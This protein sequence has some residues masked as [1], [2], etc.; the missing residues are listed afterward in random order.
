MIFS[1]F[2]IH[3][4][5]LTHINS[6]HKNQKESLTQSYGQGRDSGGI[7]SKVESYRI[8]TYSPNQL[9]GLA[10]AADDNLSSHRWWEYGWR[11]RCLTGY[12]KLR[13]RT[14]ADSTGTDLRRRSSQICV[15][16]IEHRFH[17]KYRKWTDLWVTYVRR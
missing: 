1:L 13:R 16:R 9:Q 15:G 3:L 14:P 5:S 6:G 17:R 2:E 12:D 4:D 7:E 8:C 11:R 10:L